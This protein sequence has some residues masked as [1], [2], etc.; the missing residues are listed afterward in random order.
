MRRTPQLARNLFF[1]LFVNL[2]VLVTAHAQTIQPAALSARDIARKAFPS[3][4][5][6]VAGDENDQPVAMG[7]GFFVRGNAIVT[8]HHVIESGPRL[9][10]RIA[11][12]DD[13]HDIAAIESVDEFQVPDQ[14]WR[15]VTAITYKARRSA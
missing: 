4:V 12:Q 10:T 2:L 3:V 6:V 11:G 7:S 13:Y 5:V 9:H 1:A 8:N 14:D 15:S